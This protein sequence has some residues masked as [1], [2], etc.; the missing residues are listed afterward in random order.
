MRVRG[1][2]KEDRPQLEAIL[3]A[4]EHF[5]SAEVKVAL[6]LIDIVLT[7]PGQKDYVLRCL[8]M[9]PGEVLGFICFGQAPLTDGV[10]DLYWIVVH[11]TSWNQG[12]GTRLLQNAEKELKRLGGRLLLIETSSLPGYRNPRVFYRKH[13]YRQIARIR[14]YYALGDHKL[15]FGKSFPL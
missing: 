12:V 8:E 6:E 13:G 10:Y 2:Q 4:Q 9:N 3:K 7:Q 14:D 1:I 15:V 5:R 11:P